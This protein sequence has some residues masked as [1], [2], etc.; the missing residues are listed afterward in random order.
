MPGFNIGG[1]GGDQ[2]SNVVEPRR[3][4]RWLFATIGRGAGQFS[5]AELLLLKKA[6]RPKFTFSEAKMDHNQEEVYFAG[7]QK[8][9]PIELEWYDIEQ[10]PDVSLGIYQWLGS[11]VNLPDVHVAHPR[12]YKKTAMLVMLNGFGAKNEEWTMYGT[13]PMEVDWKGLDYGSSEIQT[14]SVKMKFDRAIRSCTGLLG[15]AQT[16]TNMC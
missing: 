13:W 14:C 12:S 4:H 15:P 1:F 6:N 2:T 8:W 16:D 7:K 9:D 10:N 11:V 3:T 5:R